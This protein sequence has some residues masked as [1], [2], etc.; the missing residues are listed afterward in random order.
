M[1]EMTTNST[2]QSTEIAP[3]SAA[4]RTWL[5]TAKY[6]KVNSPVEAIPIDRMRAPRPYPVRAG[7]ERTAAVGLATQP[8]EQHGP[9][10]RRAGLDDVAVARRQRGE[11]AP[12]PVVDVPRRVAQRAHVGA[13]RQVQRPPQRL[14]R[15]RHEQPAPRDARHPGQRALRVGHVLEHLD[16]ARRVE[17]AGGERQAL[18]AQRAVLEVRRAA[19]RPLRPQAGI[20]EGGADHPPAVQ[21]PGPAL[22]EHALAAADVEQRLRV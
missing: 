16:R 15:R 10:Q 6:A 12:R 22:H 2:A 14:P 7:G 3:Y 1:T 17:L 13:A 11:R 19:P 9:G 8:D 5:A 18:A 4:G 21:A 20:V